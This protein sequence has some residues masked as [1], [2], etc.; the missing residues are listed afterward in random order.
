MDP[1]PIRPITLGEFEEFDAVTAQAFALSPASYAE[2]S[3]DLARL[4]LDR[5][6]AAFDGADQVGTAL[7]F[8]F[9]MA[10]PGNLVPSAG[11]SWVSVLPTTGGAA[12][13]TASCAASSET[14]P[15][16]AS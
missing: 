9:M 14:S 2:R 13:W 12:S 4:E 1:Y 5:C 8:S 11:V 6:I 10:V 15:N 3:R 16:A 7:V